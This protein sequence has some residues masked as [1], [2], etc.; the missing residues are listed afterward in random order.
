MDAEQGVPGSGQ[1][2]RGD[3]PL[4]GVLPFSEEYYRDLR[5]RTS[6]RLLVTYLAPLILLVVYFSVQYRGLIAGGELLHLQAIAEHQANTL[7]LFLR[8]RRINLSNLVDDPR[9]QRPASAEELEDQL[10]E[11]RRD[12]EAFVDLGCFDA[13]GIQVAY[14]GPHSSLE[15]RDYSGE[16][17]WSDLNGGDGDCVIT[18]IYMGFRKRSHFTIAVKSKRGD[19]PVVLRATLDPG[20]IYDYISRLEGQGEVQTSIVDRNGSYQLVNPAVGEVLTPSGF[21]PSAHPRL[22]TAEVRR[23]SSSSPCAYA[24]LRTVE[25]VMVVSRPENS[26]LDFLSRGGAWGTVVP[27]AVILLTSLIILIRAGRVVELQRRS[28][29]TQA[30]L[31]HASKLATVG[32]LAG[33]IAHEINNPL[34]AITEEAGLIQDLLSPE[35]AD[36]LSP[37]ELRERLTSIQESA[38]RCRD[39]THKL[40]RFVRKTEFDLKLNDLHALIDAVIDGIP[41]QGL[42]VSNIEVVR[43]YSASL[44]RFYTDGNQL[45]QVILNLLNNAVDAIGEKGGTITIRT[46]HEAKNLFLSLTDTGCGMTPEQLG[47]IFMPFYTTKEVGK[48][49]GLGLSVSFGI[50]GSMGGKIEVESEPGIGSTFTILLPVRTPSKSKEKRS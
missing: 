29:Q 31:G 12:S 39:I 21:V 25:W 33:G 16:K 45:Q 1:T 17:W 36:S 22:G 26:R 30:L 42:G 34:A 18:D 8:E 13:A 27:L 38:L 32:E 3:H 11:L 37:D 19:L 40:L 5:R 47:N 14:A 20:W 41:G 49:T 48:G 35:F 24:W 6:Y 4:T 2:G 7:D 9:T 15:R 50:V 46:R 28:D 23:G 43:E 10:K 44:P